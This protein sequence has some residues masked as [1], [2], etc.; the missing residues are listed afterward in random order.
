MIGHVVSM[1]RHPVKGF[2]PERVAAVELVE[3]AYFPCD[4][5]YAI[6][7]GPSGFDPQTPAHVSKTRYTVLASIPRVAL[8]RTEYDERTGV[9]SVSASGVEPFAGDLRE[10]DGKQ[11]F[12]AW[13]T[14]FLDPDDQ[15]GPLKVLA[16]PPY[17]F[18]DDPDGYVSVVNLASVRDLEARIGQPVDPLR[19]RANITLDGW[20]AWSELGLAPGARVSLGAATVEMLEPTVR[21]VATHVS[22]ETGERDI[23]LVAALRELYGHMHFGV[24][25]KVVAGGVVREGDRVEASQSKN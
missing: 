20:P 7:N 14:N 21:C 11:G 1:Y 2:T 22:P 9:L 25:M 24:Y 18:T 16:A 12:A 6:E 3:G 23:K 5:L 10:E 13:L 19:F 8:A 17:R 15:R 4:R